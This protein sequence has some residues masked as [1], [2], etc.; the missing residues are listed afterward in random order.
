LLGKAW[1]MLTVAV[2]KPVSAT[3]A[4]TARRARV[5]LFWAC[6]MLISFY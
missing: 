5:C 2:V 1:A 3:P 4:A 6:L